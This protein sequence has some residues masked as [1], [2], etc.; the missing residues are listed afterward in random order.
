MTPNMRSM[1]LHK[2]TATG[3]GNIDFTVTP[4]SLMSRGSLFSLPAFRLVS[5]ELHLSAAGG[6]NSLTITRDAEDGVA[7]DTVIYSVDL[8]T[9]TDNVQTW[10][11]LYYDYGDSLVVAWT[12]GSS[13]TYGLTI[14]VEELY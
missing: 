7:Y 9:L 2:F 11:N 6:D 8:S 12:N 3:S 5:F 4:S 1:K 10:D 13:R 14:R